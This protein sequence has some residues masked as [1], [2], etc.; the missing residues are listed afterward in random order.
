MTKHAFDQAYYARFYEDQA[1]RAV[2]PLEQ[3]QLAEFIASY[4]RYLGAE[5]TSILDVGCGLGQMLQALGATFE[6]AHTEGVE[7]SDFLCQE[8]GWTQGSVVDYD[9]P[10]RDL[11]ICNDVFGYLTKKQAKRA[12]TNLAR[13][14]RQVLY[15]SVLTEEDLEVCDQEHTDMQQKIRPAQWYKALLATHFVAVGGGLFL[16]KPLALPVWQM[17][18]T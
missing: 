10:A 16:K 3:Q 4:V 11:V 12:V 17:E 6:G 5:V 9:G 13:L 7:F 15:F 18:R 8:L 1:T 2:S 14:T